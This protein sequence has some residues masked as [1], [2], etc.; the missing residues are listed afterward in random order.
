LYWDNGLGQAVGHPGIVGI[1]QVGGHRLG[2]GRSVGLQ[3]AAVLHQHQGGHVRSVD[4]VGLQPASVGLGQHLGGDVGRAAAEIFDL[5]P[6]LVGE[7][8]DDRVEDLGIQARVEDH[9]SLATRLLKVD[10]CRGTLRAQVRAECHGRG[11]GEKATQDFPTS[12]LE[13]VRD[14]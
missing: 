6:I 8:R 14:P 10:R 9:R 1:A 4:D 13:H 5:D 7:R 11:T 2:G 12:Q 3:D